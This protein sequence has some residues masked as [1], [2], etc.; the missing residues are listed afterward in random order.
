MEKRPF[1]KPQTVSGSGTVFFVTPLSMVFWLKKIII[2]ENRVLKNAGG[3]T[4]KIT[5]VGDGFKRVDIPISANIIQS[6]EPVTD[7][8]SS[9]GGFRGK[10]VTWR[11]IQIP[12]GDGIEIEINAHGV[13]GAEV[14]VIICGD[15]EGEF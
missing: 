4:L 15:K 12:G 5:H 14:E 10:G 1:Y 11:N 9:R 6:F 8:A 3:A 7:T 13:V 2:K